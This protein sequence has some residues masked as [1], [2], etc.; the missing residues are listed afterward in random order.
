VLA[1]LRAAVEADRDAWTAQAAAE[2]QKA[3]IKLATGLRMATEAGASL[4]DNIGMLGMFNQHEGIN[5]LAP[6][7]PNDSSQFDINVGIEGLRA[8]LSTATSELARYKPAK[9]GRVKKAAAA[10]DVDE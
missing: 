10:E 1:D 4:N 7:H 3:L 8:G 9:S 5:R 2:A 6:F